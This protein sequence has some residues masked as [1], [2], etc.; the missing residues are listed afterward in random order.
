MLTTL[1]ESVPC[2]LRYEYINPNV[3]GVHKNIIKLF[4]VH[5]SLSLCFLKGRYGIFSSIAFC[6]LHSMI[7]YVLKVEQ[8]SSTFC[9]SGFIPSDIPPPQGPLW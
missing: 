5:I 9:I 4:E 6:D 8:G 2:L 7:Q 3:M 1:F